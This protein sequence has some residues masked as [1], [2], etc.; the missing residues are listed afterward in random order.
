VRLMLI[1]GP[2]TGTQPTGVACKPIQT[3]I[4]E[5]LDYLKANKIEIH[6]LWLDVEPTSGVCNAWKLS[7]SSNFNLAKQWT[8]TLRNT[9][10]KWGIYGNPNQWEE[11]FPS[12]SSNIGSDLP[13]WVVIDDNMAGVGAISQGQLMGGWEISNLLAKQFLLDTNVCGA[14][15]DKDS[16]LE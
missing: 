9:G 16:F 14:S 5:L 4:N 12:R 15:L 3:Q 13:L 7:K 6:R 1:T 10:L 8:N 2:G 11:M